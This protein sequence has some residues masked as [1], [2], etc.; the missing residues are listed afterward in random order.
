M[1]VVRFSSVLL[2]TFFVFLIACGQTTE[3]IQ[4]AVAGL[5]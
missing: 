2:L 4:L 3:E 1:F 5:D